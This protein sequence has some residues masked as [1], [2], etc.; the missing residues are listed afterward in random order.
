MLNTKSPIPLY[1]QLAD[2]LTRQVREGE[3]QPGDNIPSE[4]RMAKEYGIGRPT[5]RQAM[6]LLVRKGL[7]ERKRG[8]GTYVREQK[9]SVDL[10]SLAGTSQ[11]FEIEGIKTV[12]K[13]IKPICIKAVSDDPINPFNNRDA[14]FI[15]R[16]TCVDAGPV[17]LEDI[18]LHPDVFP[19][20]E[21]IDIENQSLAQVA[22]DHYYLKPTTGS[23]TFKIDYLKEDRAGCLSLTTADPV[24]AVERFLWFPNAGDAV[25]SR[26]YCRTDRFAFSQT[27]GVSPESIS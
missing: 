21:K 2:L 12:V 13:L 8:S 20:L 23:Q 3:Y 15:S 9:P 7:V 14:F 27:I 18:Y 25:F 16:I 24:L 26:L 1:H 4:T 5:V 19:G 17:L 22:A 6:D 11:A 10:F